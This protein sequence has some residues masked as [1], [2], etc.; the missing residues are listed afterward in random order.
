MIIERINSD[1]AN[2]LGNLINRTIAMVK[3]YFDGHVAYCNVTED[4]DTELI[5]SINTLDE[6]VT[7]RMDHLE[8]GR[9]I[10]E[11]FDLLRRSNKYI[12][13]TMPWILSKDEKQK[14]RLETVLYHLLEAIRVTAIYITPFLPDTGKEILRQINQSIDNNQFTSD[15]I[16]DVLD[17]QVLFQRIVIEK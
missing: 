4:V 2:V 15:L 10:D 8:I 3:K 7:K 16:Y 14:E 6:R 13:E 9:A 1:L 5:C 11:I 17:P 12:D